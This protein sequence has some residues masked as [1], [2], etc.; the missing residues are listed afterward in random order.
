[1]NFYW[2][3]IAT[4]AV[5]RVTYFLHAEDGPADVSRRLRDIAGA[6]FFGRLL[7]CFYCLSL[8]T[9]AP[10]ALAIGAG[11]TETI[12]LWLALSAGA[13]VIERVTEP[14]DAP[15]AVIHDESEED[16]DELLREKSP[17]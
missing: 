13:I 15:A 10:F 16:S 17:H 6:G 3:L 9:A 4:L 7:G 14:A 2:M 11:A 5:W 1:M 12:C 8:W